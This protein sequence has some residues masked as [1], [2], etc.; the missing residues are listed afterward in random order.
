[1]C[2]CEHDLFHA[3]YSLHCMYVCMYVCVC[4]CVRVFVCVHRY[5]SGFHSRQLVTRSVD[6]L[7][8]NSRTDIKGAQRSGYCGERERGKGMDV[9]VRSQSLDLESLERQLEFVRSNTFLSLS[10]SLSLSL[11]LRHPCVHPCVA[12]LLTGVFQ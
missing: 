6:S 12:V 11:R 8:S 3:T 1:M 7:P 5:G 4:M 10:L 2:L 9:S